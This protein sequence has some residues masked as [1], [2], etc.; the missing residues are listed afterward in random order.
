MTIIMVR[1]TLARRTSKASQAE[2]QRNAP[3]NEQSRI[4]TRHSVHVLEQF[5]HAF[6]SQIFGELNHVL[7]H[8]RDVAGQSKRVLAFQLFCSCFGTLRDF[9]NLISSRLAVAVELRLALS[10]DLIDGLMSL[11]L[12]LISCLMRFSLRVF[13][14]VTVAV[15][16]AGIWS[17]IRSGS[18]A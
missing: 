4:I 11:S 2:A 8:V 10:L 14:D 7:R 13:G 12:Y 5:I 6:A 16:E 9:L 1:G 17:L 15:I 18:L 3:G